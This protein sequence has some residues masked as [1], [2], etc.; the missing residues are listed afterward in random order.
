M[1]FG[2]QAAIDFLA[3]QIQHDDPGASSHWRLHHKN[4]A[5]K[6]NGG[7]SGCL[8]SEGRG[9]RIGAPVLWFTRPCNGD[10]GALRVTTR[11]LTG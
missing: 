3:S 6:G 4:F 7:F 1:A 8:A 9:A 5:L 11:S 2:G 10:I